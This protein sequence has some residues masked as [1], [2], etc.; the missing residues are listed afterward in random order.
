MQP[1]PER[2]LK[3]GSHRIS[4]ISEQTDDS[5]SHGKPQKFASS[6]ENR[7]TGELFSEMT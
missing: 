2:L 7:P 3:P 4:K 6:H 5:F 1:L